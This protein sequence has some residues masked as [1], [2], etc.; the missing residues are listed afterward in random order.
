MYLVF[1]VDAAS[2]AAAPASDDV[3]LMCES[4]YVSR[5]VTSHASGLP[6][7]HGIKVII[8][9]IIII[10]TCYALVSINK[11]VKYRVTSAE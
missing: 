10:L 7:H 6:F 3:I 11:H 5:T 1:F 9:I 4:A 2:L 8:I